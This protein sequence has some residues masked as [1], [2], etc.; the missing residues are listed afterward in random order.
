[1]DWQYGE[2][3]PT[4]KS[5]SSVYSVDHLNAINNLSSQI[6]NLGKEMSSIKAKLESASSQ[7][8]ILPSKFKGRGTSFNSNPLSS[9]NNMSSGCLS[10]DVCGSYDHDASNCPHAFPDGCYDLDSNENEHVNYVSNNNNGPR[11]EWLGQEKTVV[12]PWYKS[13]DSAGTPV[14]DVPF[15][16]P[17]V[18]STP[19]D[20]ILEESGSS[21]GDEIDQEAGSTKST[22]TPDAPQ[23]NEE[24]YNWPSINN[25]L[26]AHM[27]AR[28][29]VTLN[30]TLLT[31]L[32]KRPKGL[33]MTPPEETPAKSTAEI[34][35]EQLEQKRAQLA[36]R[37]SGTGS[38][39]ILRSL[40]QIVRRPGEELSQPASHRLR[41]SGGSAPTS[42][43]GVP[44]PGRPTTAGKS[45]Q[46]LGLSSGPAGVGSRE[47]E[48]PSSQL[49]AIASGSNAAG[50]GGTPQLD[51]QDT[52]S[53]W[54]DMQNYAKRM[55]T[56]T[57]SKR[58]VV[59][60]INQVNLDRITSLLAEALKDAEKERARLKDEVT[61]LR[62][63]LDKTKN[64]LVK[65][66]KEAL[67][68]LSAEQ[69]RLVTE[70]ERD[71]EARMKMAWSMIHPD[72]DYA[73]FDLR[74]KYGTEVF[75]AQVLGLKQPAPFEKWADIGDEQAEEEVPGGEKETQPQQTQ[76]AP[77]AG[78]GQQPEQQQ[79]QQQQQ[80]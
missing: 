10:C 55:L 1:M 31:F 58:E 28:D 16:Q 11:T 23:D 74:Y 48:A 40:R 69:T 59:P 47:P 49:L 56:L 21:S 8:P 70:N 33:E 78:Q 27:S 54:P 2:R 77:N 22:M 15:D 4:S 32:E 7:A 42:A 29:V 72:T 62:E 44:A 17:G 36:A 73:F 51:N 6:S 35:K 5:S 30:A 65:S 63:E 50:G 52:A 18:L 60:G 71:C 20:E 26:E 64:E 41:V 9:S 12:D 13:D 80:Q 38:Q 43:G 53:R 76:D 79:Q 46:S 45:L 66:M 61:R 57:R 39:N 75:D 3:E 25:P 37:T 67:D 14:E 24:A 34:R 19:G 68:H